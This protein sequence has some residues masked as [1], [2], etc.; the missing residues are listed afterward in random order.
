MSDKKH[1]KMRKLVRAATVGMVQTV[2][3]TSANGRTQELIHECSRRK[4]QNLK[5]AY[6]A[7]QVEV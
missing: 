2:Y 7:G 3:R 4:L 1:K 6:K 5:R